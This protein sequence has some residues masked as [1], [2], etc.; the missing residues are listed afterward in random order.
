MFDV[1]ET[2]ARGWIAV[3]EYLEAH[4]MPFIED[5]LHQPKS[6]DIIH[7]IKGDKWKVAVMSDL[8]IG[9]N[10]FKKD[11]MQ[12]FVKYALD[13]GV[14][15]FLLPGDI[16]DGT[17]V[18]FGMEYE[19]SIPGIDNQI[20]YF[21]EIFPKVPKA[22]MII[23]NH[24]Y[25]SFKSIGKNIGLDI[26]RNRPDFKYIGCMEGR[27][28]INGILMELFH[29]Q[30]S[31]AYTL[32]YKLQKRIENYVPGNKPRFLFMGHY[33]QAVSITSRNVSAYLCGS[34]QGA[35]TFS[36]GLNLPNVTGGWIL[37]IMSDG[38]EVNSV[39]S[40]FIQFY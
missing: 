4:N 20:S 15:T 7:Q 29:G 9:S 39:K 27:V 33:H 17:K 13:S 36:K 22:F 6:Q 14:E 35:N 34:F 30:G 3:A 28:T 23:G 2:V 18:Y 32:S 24:E 12:T 37:E 19:Q 16:I 21:E 26:C 11:E 8:H 38:D 25:A 40:E 1:S 31:G 10:V 5:P